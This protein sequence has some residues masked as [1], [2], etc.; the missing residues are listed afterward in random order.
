MKRRIKHG[1][2]LFGV[3]ALIVGLCACM[4]VTV[5]E[6]TE[7]EET[8]SSTPIEPEVGVADE[9]AASAPEETGAPDTSSPVES[10]AA[11]DEADFEVKEVTFFSDEEI[12]GLVESLQSEYTYDQKGSAENSKQGIPVPVTGYRTEST[13]LSV[14]TGIPIYYYDEGEFIYWCL[15]NYVFDDGVPVYIMVPSA[16]EPVMFNAYYADRQSSNYP[17][18]KEVFDQSTTKEFCL[19]YCA[20]GNVLY[21]GV[22]AWLLTNG[23]DYEYE[24]FYDYLD[25]DMASTPGIEDLDCAT[26]LERQT[27]AYESPID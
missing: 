2:V 5:S 25:D 23:H 21:D 4:S 18:A 12:A 19:I 1:F 24:A 16:F 9:P 17:T 3:A 6:T 27:F 8:L 22:S 13:E 11:V 26:I 7:I 20:Q 15:G 10:E 14:A